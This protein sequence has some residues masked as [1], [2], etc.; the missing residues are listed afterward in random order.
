ML[1]RA[2]IKNVGLNIVAMLEYEMQM[3]T[4]TMASSDTSLNINMWENFV[5]TSY[6]VDKVA[7]QAYLEGHAN[8]NAFCILWTGRR[9]TLASWR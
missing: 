4:A 8:P 5:H 6:P 3:W 7:S 2:H 9:E 1:L